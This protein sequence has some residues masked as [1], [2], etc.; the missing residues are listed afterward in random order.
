MKIIKGT[1][2]IPVEHP[3]F[4]LFGQP[5]ICKTSLG[6]S[7]KEPLLLDFDGGAYRS[8]NRRDT[9]PINTWADVEDLKETLAPYSTVVVDTVGRCLDLMTID[10]IE[11][12]S[13]H[14]RDGSLTLQGFG[15]LKA[16]FRTWMT[17]LRAMGK[18]VVLISHHKEEKDGDLTVSRP[19][20]TGSSCG[21]VMKISDFVGFVY[22]NG[23]D[24]IV[25]FN[26]TD[27]WFGK[28]PANWKSMPVPPIA[29]ATTFIADLI[30][31]GRAELGK[32]SEESSK[33]ASQVNDWRA[34]IE[35]FT[36][37]DEINQ[38]IPECSKLAAIVAPQVKTLLM[39]RAK[40]L[41]FAWSA[42]RK[43]FV[44]PAKEEVPA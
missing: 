6:Y 44:E 16:R 26:P 11:K 23:R 1:E 40:A 19:D 4:C 12:N 38:A 34:Q 17:Q 8:V 35:T 30:E 37:V 41:K 2:S 13:K 3:V 28:N 5:G 24:R 36:T 15:V 43:A 33:V 18:D 10:I 7:A 39:T 21:E 9:G 14:G 29:K 27:R 31:K 32:I 20:I 22:M 25:D 42:D